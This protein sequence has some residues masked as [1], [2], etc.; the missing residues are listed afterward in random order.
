M[1][2]RPI[3]QF[4][5][6][7]TRSHP[8]PRQRCLS[9]LVSLS[10][11]GTFL[12][13]VVLTPIAAIAQ[14]V[15]TSVRQGYTLLERGWVDQAIEVFEQAVRANPQS[16]EGRLGL[17]IAYRRAGRDEPAFRTYETVLQLDPDNRLALSAL[18][19]LGGFRPEWQVRGIEALTTLLSLEPDNIDARSQRAL[20]YV[21]QGQF[22]AAL[23]DYEAVL[24]Q[25]P[26][27]EVLVG[28][29][30]AYTYSGNYDQAL[31]L[32]SRHQ[33]TGSSLNP[34]EAI[35]YSVALRETGSAAQAVNVLDNQLQQVQ[36]TS[37]AAVR[38]RGALASAYAAAGQ[39]QAALQAIA[40]LQGRFD[41]RLTLARAYSDIA[42]YSNDASYDQAAAELYRQVLTQTP[43]LTAGMA[44]EIADALSTI[45]SEQRY[46]LTVYQQLVQQYPGD[47]SLQVQQA[48]LERNLGLISSAELQSRLQPILQTVPNDALQQRTI[49]Q[50]LIRLDPPDVA[51]LPL[52]QNLAQ[53]G[54][55]E[56]FLY[57]RIAQIFNQQGQY[58]AARD[59]LSVYA[60][61][62]AGQ[63]D[64]FANLLLLAEIERREGNLDASAQRYQTILAASPS[65]PQVLTGALQGY[66]TVLQ[67]QGRVDE[68]IA[69]YDQVIALNPQDLTK[70]LGRASLAY[71]ADRISAAE[72]EA[73]LGQWVS[74]RPADDTPP[75]L[76]SLVGALPAD[77]AR[78]PL[79]DRL[80]AANPDS[81][82]V[83]IRKIQ[84]VATR[85]PDLAQAQ[86]AQLIA[87]NPDNLSV[88]FVQGQVAQDLGELNLAAQAYETILTEEP[89]NTG[90]LLALG[91]VQFQQRRLESAA[92]SYN[93]ALALEPQNRDAHMALADLTVVEGRRLAALRQLEQWQ[94]E[95]A[96][97][98]VVDEE[99]TRQMQRIREGYLQQR[100]FQPP[101]ERF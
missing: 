5:K 23:E 47:R 15:P 71:Q 95:Q 98:G 63:R 89:N 79:Y 39:T 66:A 69:L 82:P 65:D 90:A 36:P 84:L 67:A 44:R 70:Q 75:E 19:I 1:R 85:S 97:R 72:A 57:F 16:V 49:A 11:L 59:A 46:A 52:Y 4:P 6:I 2:T 94:V 14:A 58:D 93:Q 45:P 83:Q 74:S 20:L 55:N 22:A 61:S 76:Y 38:L 41:S 10:L 50:T 40:P 99:V 18:G 73:V 77:P 7:L 43:D 86:V 37:T 100:G 88:Y 91:G 87:R 3:A 81:I 21:Y 48:V 12:G 80:L 78:E 31:S 56:P 35:A 64:P 25:N 54:V 53:S 29:A 96:A 17:A 68:A 30:Q 62:P 13:P 26:T 60:A 42:R 32:F 27:P 24:Q 92:R 8:S 9:S 33:A 28:A 101:W 51:L 34:D